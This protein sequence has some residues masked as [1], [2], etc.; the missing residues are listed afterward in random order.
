VFGVRASR[1]AVIVAAAVA[2]VLVVVIAARHAITRAVLQTVLSGATGYQVTI[3][4]QTLGTRHAVLFDVHVVK[5]GDPVL[6]AQRVDVDYAL[7][8]IFPGGQHRFGFAAIAIQKP[9]LTIT[10]HADGTLTFNRTGGTSG[11]PPAPTRKAAAPLYFTA[12]IREGTIRLIDAAPLQRDLAYQSIENVSIDASVKSDARTTAKVDGVL[13]ARRAP[14]APIARYPLSERTVIDVQRGIALNRITARELPMR[15]ALGFFIH[16]KSF[17]FDDGVLDDVDARYY[18]LAPKAGDEFAYKLGGGAHLRGGALYVSA[19][20]HEIRDVDA[21]L[22]ITDD[23]IATTSVTAAIDGIPVRGRGAMYSLFSAPTFRLAFAASS[24]LHDVRSLFTFLA[25]MPLRGGSHFETLLASSLSKPLIRTRFSAPHLSY[26]KYPADAV[27]GLIDYYDGAITFGGVSAR[28]GSVNLGLG[29]RVI[30]GQDGK[31]DILIAV[32]AAGA[33]SSLP[34]ADMLAP[35]A[36]VIATVLLNEPPGEA[37]NARGTIGAVGRT[38][39]A[40]TFSVDQKGVGEFGPL[41]FT[42]SNGESFAGAFELERPISQSAGWIHARNFRLAD[43]RKAATLPGGIAAAIPPI[44]GVIDGDFAGGGSPD[45]FGIAGTMRGRDL[46][47]GPYALGSGT[48]RLGGSFS[49]IRLSANLAGPLG[50]FSGEGAYDGDVFALQGDYDGRLESLRPFIADATAQGAVHGPIRATIGKNR[51]VVQT[52]GAE[53]PGARIRGVAVDRVAGTLAVD[54][55]KTLRLI[56][57]DGSLGGGQ[58]VA[59]DAGGPFLVSAP[60]VPV[61]ALRGAGLPLQAGTLAFFGLADIR[62]RSPSFDGLVGVEDGRAAGYPISGGADLALAGGTANVRRGV[63]ALGTTYGTFGG[64]VYGIGAKGADALAYDLN[65]QVPIGDVGEV[66]RALRLPVK[67][68]EGSF[69]ADVRVRGNGARPR[70]GGEV[71]V[72]EGSYNGLAF[73]DARAGVAITTSSIAASRGVVTVGSTRANVDAAASIARGAFSV[74]VRSANANLADFDDYFDEAETLAGQGPVALMFA[75]DG[76]ATRTSGHVNVTGFRYRRFTFGTTDATWSQRGGTVA[77]ALN[78][79]GAHGALRANGSMAPASGG[80]VRAI[81]DASYRANVS[82]QQV[83]LATWLPPFG[84]TAPLLGQV[85]ANGTIAGRW[86]RLGVS[87][88][89]TLANGSIFGYKVVAASAHARSAGD[90][91]S[92]AGSA[93]DLGFARFDATGS[94][95]FS[96]A[97]PLALSVRAQSPDVAKAL[98]AVYPKG[99][100]YDVGGALTANALIGGSLAKPRATVGFEMTNARYKTLAIPRVL[101]NVGYDGK[102]L[103]VNDAEATFAKGNVVVTGLLPLTLEPLG[104]TRDAPLSFSVAV[105][106][107]DLAP[108]APF[109]PGPHTKLG[110]TAD[111]RLSIEGTPAAPRVAGTIALANGMYVSDL[112]RAAITN[113]NA[114]LAFSGTSV[115]LQAL[116]AN[117]GGGTLDGGGRLDLPLPGAKTGNYAIGLT[118]HGARVDSPTYGRGVVDGTMRLRSATPKPVLSGDVTLSNASIPILSIYRSASGGAGGGGSAGGGGLPFDVALD[119]IAHAGKNVR[120]QASSP[121]I[122]I[123]TTGTLDLTG[124]LSAPKLAG[125]L[126]ATPGGVFSTYNRAFRVQQ[127]AVAFNPQNGL[128]PYIDLRAYA[129]VTNPDPDP[130]RNSVGSADITVSVDGPADELAAGTGSVIQ[131]SS[132]PP[133]S[134]EQIIGLLL[135]ASVFGAVNFGQQQNGTTLRGA[136]GESNPL[137]PPGVTAY[138][139][140]VINFNQEAFSVLNG[141]LT[142]RFLAPVE[143]IFT[144]RFGLTDFEL[145]VDYGGGVGYNALKQIGKRDVYASFGQTLSRPVRTQFGFTARPDATTSVQFSYFTQNGVPAITS[146]ANGTSAFTGTQRLQGIQPVSNRQGFTFSIVRKYP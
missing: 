137:L 92:I 22:V 72:P 144:G 42:R 115:A 82:A 83:D 86:P 120:V 71:A 44:A 52:T 54:D 31:N 78:V 40:G 140:G 25:K 113:A 85:S 139:A 143:R 130:T 91:V 47:Y 119:V 79:R 112:D 24:D 4:G 1:R 41:A 88:D 81:E 56:A 36:N 129:H 35:D 103:N 138:Q 61:A 90:R 5:N 62:G 89:A 50:R 60:A 94:F 142:Q 67:Y 122:D 59:S 104:V 69:S 108:F 17:R 80:P 2:A 93:L 128:L 58:V 13:V 131:Y 29:G 14:G 70:I 64:R 68:L 145:T 32:N 125:V 27:D 33:G 96:T 26:D 111:G 87:G 146:N 117:V 57:A 7:R 53:L 9:V 19:L 77:A 97:A 73:R 99:P 135:D 110:G 136:P 43:V 20:A 109:V 76:V 12:R 6:D 84:I 105:S 118:A 116:H 48:V 106:G 15:G 107:L 101:G 49:D 23:A 75:N 55:G 16:S 121:Y 51:I 45:T 74:D 133:Y 63:A 65:A 10:R 126:T 132:N 102:T 141:Q 3:G 34:Y 46:R 28:Y 37:F 134:Q 124:S 39:G 66:R 30:L 100:R 98:A 95:G 11:T 123:G 38:T 8:D 18:A 127:A 114:Q 21:P